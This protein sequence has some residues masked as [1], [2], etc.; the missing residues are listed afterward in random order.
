MNPPNS[1]MAS[2][3]R[4]AHRADMGQM[5]MRLDSIVKTDGQIRPRLQVE[6]PRIGVRVYLQ[7]ELPAAAESGHQDW[8]EEAYERAVIVL[9]PA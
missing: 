5:T 1:P 6:A 8:V 4:R 3:T 7:V 9:D 2:R